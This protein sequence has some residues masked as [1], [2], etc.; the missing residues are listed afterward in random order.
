MSGWLIVLTGCAAATV[1]GFLGAPLLLWT[2]GAGGILFL[3]GAPP[4]A[5]YLLL[6]FGIVFNIRPLRALLVSPLL[7]SL[8]RRMGLPPAIS[9]T[10]S[11]ALDAGTV[12]MDAEL[13]SGRPNFRRILEQPMPEL[14]S[15]EQ[16]FLDG[17]VEK[18][19]AMMDDWDAHCRGDLSPEVWQALKDHGFFG[20]IIPGDYGGHGFSTAGVSAIIQKLATRSFPLAV[21]VMIPN[22]LGPAELLN[23][24]GTEEQKREYLPKLARGEHMPCFALTEPAAG[25][26][27]ASISSSGVLFRDGNGDLKMRLNWDKRYTSLA[28]VA[29]LVGLAFRLSDPE[30][31]L[32]RGTDLGITCALIPTGTP[33]VVI[34]ERHDPLGVPFYNCP[35]QGHDVVVSVDQ[36]IGGVECAGGGWKMLMECLAAG[37]GVSLPAS[38]VAGAKIAARVAGAYS[39]VRQQFGMSVGRFEG[40]EEPLARIGSMT[41]LMDAVR[42]YTCGALD[43]GAQPAVV[44]AIVKYNLTELA[45]SVTNDAMDILGGAAISRGP[46]NL[47]ANCYTAVP[48]GITVEGA[49]ILTRSLIIFGQGALRCHPWAYVWM[50]ALAAGDMRGFDRGF[51]GHVGHFV[52]NVVRAKLLFISRG[53]LSVPPVSGPMSRY[54]RKLSWASANFAAMADLS[55]T[56]L[57][58]TGELKRRQKVT[59]RMADQFS[60]M[61]LATAT[62]CR[63]EA[64]GS[65]REDLPLATWALDHAFARIQEA[66][67][68]VLANF[69]VPILGWSLRGPLALVCRLNPMG[70]EPSDRNGA[71]VAEILR[72]PGEQRER[73]CSGMYLPESTS[74]ALG[75]LEAA[76]LAVSLAEAPVRKIRKA[77]RKGTL[78]RQDPVELLDQAVAADVVDSDEAELV[79]VAAAARLDAIQVDGFKLDEYLRATPGPGHGAERKSGS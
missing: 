35:I 75:R 72:Q 13:F 57:E 28:A 8:F 71:G 34:E 25:S 50:K 5:W 4:W 70:T 29:T 33:G 48:I 27:A 11:E 64:E 32:G 9:D 65:R 10:E 44:S 42:R 40:I 14:T 24:Y 21:S 46:R 26:D 39:T 37:R 45:R 53:W 55:M 38:S 76:F 77:I 6:A 66:N 60:W 51:W 54:W 15:T 67:Q 1:L 19:C 68:G 30:E 59:G 3:S 43:S 56:C 41:Y 31:L 18:V 78:P 7:A 49:N 17:P 61:Y 62:L 16:E 58:L 63:F 12:W 20:M 79:R 47:L 69:P 22:S 2:L 52:R 74:E 73:L 36:I 23:H